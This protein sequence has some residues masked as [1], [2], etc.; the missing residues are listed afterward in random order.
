MI[1]KKGFALQLQNTFPL[2]IDDDLPVS[3]WSTLQ[4]KTF[5]WKELLTRFNNKLDGVLHMANIDEGTMYAFTFRCKVL[6]AN[7]T[8]SPKFLEN[9][10]SITSSIEIGGEGRAVSAASGRF[11]VGRPRRHWLSARRNRCLSFAATRY[12]VS[13]ATASALRLFGGGQHHVKSNA[14]D[15]GIFL[16]VEDLHPAPQVLY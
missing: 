9:V 2:P 1:E 4:E 16:P 11:R 12:S 8:P 5:L 15:L 13:T 7:P 3:L 10:R 6:R 14:E